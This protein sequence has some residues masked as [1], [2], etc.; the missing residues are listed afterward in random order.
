V[1]VYIHGN[2]PNDTAPSKLKATQV[3]KRHVKS[4]RTSLD[5]FQDFSLF[6]GETRMQ[7]PLALRGVVDAIFLRFDV[8]V[9]RILCRSAHKE[10]TN[11]QTG[12][13]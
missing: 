8:F 7:G 6:G 9:V 3:E 10:L 5:L 12:L 13:D 11:T 4:I 2:D 1:W